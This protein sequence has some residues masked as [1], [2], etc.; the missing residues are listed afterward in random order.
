MHLL[1]ASARRDLHV[2]EGAG[3]DDVQH[4]NEVGR[5]AATT[6][7]GQF[8][9]RKPRSKQTTI[10]WQKNFQIRSSQGDSDLAKCCVAFGVRG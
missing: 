6:V 8:S 1:R 10:S 2:E 9:A 5:K 3:D 4:S 7:R